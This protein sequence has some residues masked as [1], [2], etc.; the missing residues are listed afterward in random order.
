MTSFSDRL[1]AAIRAKKTPTLVGL[2]PRWA[3][4]PNKLTENKSESNPCKVADVFETFCRTIIDVVSPLV[5][6][7]KP[8]AAFFEQYG[9]LG[10]QCLSNVIKYA[11]QKGLLVVLDG[12][13]N[14]IGSTAT[15]YAKVTQL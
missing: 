13:R 12:K 6:A 10:M 3:L 9:P 15:A 1:E 8:Q 4:I 11:S 7:V 5:P 2:D 14:D